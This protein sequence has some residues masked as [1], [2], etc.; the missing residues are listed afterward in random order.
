M[1]G[2]NNNLAF[3]G[4]LGDKFVHEI[5]VKR[6]AVSSRTLLEASKSSFMGLDSSKVGD[7]FESLSDNLMKVANEKRSLLEKIERIKDDLPKQIEKEFKFRESKILEEFNSILTKQNNKIDEQYKTILTLKAYESMAKVK[8]IHRLDTIMPET[9]IK[10]YQEM[11]EHEKEARESMLS[12]LLTGKGQEP[13]LEQLE[14]NNLNLKAID[15]GIT[16]IPEVIEALGTAKPHAVDP[17][18]F[19]KSLAYDALKSEKGGVIKSPVIRTQL[20]TNLMALIEP[21]C[22]KN[23]FNASKTYME[24]V[25][26]KDFDN[27]QE[28]HS[29]LLRTKQEVKQNY[30]NNKIVYNQDKARIEVLDDE[31]KLITAQLIL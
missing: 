30:P 20:K 10:N 21:H 31:G 4:A 16:E 17:M 8:P 2:I 26:D 25:I 24:Q 7:I 22:Q 1:N 11:Q 29:N 18:Y 12:F 28:F 5:T 13:A 19:L 3:K 9:V 15:D 14:R 23:N 6:N 27:L